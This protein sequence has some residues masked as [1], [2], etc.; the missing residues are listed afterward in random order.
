MKIQTLPAT[1]LKVDVGGHHSRKWWAI[2]DDKIEFADLFASTF[3]HH[4]QNTLL[5]NDVIRVRRRDGAYDCEI[6]VTGKAENGAVRVEPWP[7]YPSDKAVDQASAQPTGM[8]DLPLQVVPVHSDGE[9]RARCQY[10]PATRWRVLGW[11]G[12]EVSRDHETEAKARESLTK[13]LSDLRMR[14]PTAE[15]LAAARAEIESKRNKGRA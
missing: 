4:H 14:M 11:D 12:H 7:L 15:E 8:V 10:L 2:V 5:P 3:W 9:P 6:T 13:Y 1:D